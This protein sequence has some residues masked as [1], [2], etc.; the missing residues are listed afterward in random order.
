MTDQWIEEYYN[1]LESK[2]KDISNS[3]FR[4][5]N[6]GRLPL[7]AIK[8]KEYSE[9]CDICKKN[10]DILAELGNML[11]Q[12]FEKPS[13]RKSFEERK[14]DIEIHLKETHHLRPAH[15]YYSLYSFLGSV[16]GLVLGVLLSLL[17]SNNFRFDIPII[18]SA[19]GL[20]F[21]QFIGKKLDKK[22]NIQNRQI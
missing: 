14:N 11:P 12:C 4:F 13:A 5:Y 16:F 17:L 8:T 21:G 3:D 20:F 18:S 7:I 6:I 15:Y 22:K 10:L 1:L 2:R 19:L 9:S